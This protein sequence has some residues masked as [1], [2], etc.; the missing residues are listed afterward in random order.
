MKCPRCNGNG[1]V[2]SPG[3]FAERLLM[4]REGRSLGRKD[5][6]EGAGIAHSE[7]WRLEN[8]T[9]QNPSAKTLVALA[10]FYGVTTDSLLGVSP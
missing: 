3:T 1:E 9:T 8:G 4:L 2:E 5:V 10:K 6:E 7:Y